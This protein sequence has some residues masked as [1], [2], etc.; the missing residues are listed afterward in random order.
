MHRK[1]NPVDFARDAIDHNCDDTN[2]I[3]G[4]D[5]KR[6]EFDTF[7]KNRMERSICQKLLKRIQSMR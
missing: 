5:F 2:M 7:N 6:I 3:V 1:S 4:I